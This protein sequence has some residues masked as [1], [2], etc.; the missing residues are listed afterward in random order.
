MNKKLFYN[1]LVIGFIIYLISR[2]SNKSIDNLLLDYFNKIKDIIYNI[3][4]IKKKFTNKENIKEKKE[5]DINKNNKVSENVDIELTNNK[6]KDQEDNQQNDQEDQEDNQQNDNLYNKAY[7]IISKKVKKIDLPL[8]VSIPKLCSQNDIKNIVKFLEDKYNFLNI[9]I[10]NDLEFYH[11]SEIYELKSILVKCLLYS[12][13]DLLGECE[14]EF[15]I[16][17]NK[18]DD[19]NIFASS[20]SFNNKQGNFQISNFN[21]INV[22]ESNNNIKLENFDTNSIDSLIPDNIFS[23][24]YE[25]DSSNYTTESEIKHDTA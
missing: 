1:I 19:N 5:I 12:N 3:F 2:I 11:Y 18:I 20:Y 15:N 7:N 21:L 9:E 8:N 23:S 13:K 16:V 25:Q 22:K 14:I 4:N 17:F 6:Q 24:E 10:S